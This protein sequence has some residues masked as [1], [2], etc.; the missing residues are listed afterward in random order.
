MVE[1]KR[2]RPLVRLIRFAIFASVSVVLFY[3]IGV[4]VFLSTSL[5]TR[6][7]DAQPDVVDIHFE[8]AWSIF[9]QHVHAKKL[10]IRG[11]DGNVE[12]I[13]KLDEAELDIALVSLLKMRFEGSH[14]RGKG[15][16]FRMRQRPDVAPSAEELASL[17]A[18]DGLAPYSI[19]PP[20]TPSPD[21]WNDA[22]YHLWTLDLEDVIAEDVREVWVDHVRYEGSAYVA[23]RF[24][25]KP[26]RK[27]EVGPLRVL[28]ERGALSSGKNRVAEA[29]DGSSADVTVEPFDP[30]TATLTDIVH[31]L[32]CVSDVHA[33][34]PEPG[35][36][37]PAGVNVH[38]PVELR[39][40]VLRITHGR[41]EN[42]SH[43]V[44]AAPKAVVSSGAYRA[45]GAITLDG[46]VESDRLDFRAEIATLDARRAT[47]PLLRASKAIATGDAAALDLTHAFEDLH[48]VVDVPDADLGSVRKLNR[49]IPPKTP[50]AIVKGDAR[51]DLHFEAWRAD[52]RATGRAT[53]RSDNLDFRLAKMNVR[54][55]A[56]VNAAFAS[57]R[58]G[59]RRLDGASLTIDV[60]NGELASADAPTTPLVRV[61]QARLTARASKMDSKDPLRDLDVSIS[62]PAADVVSSDL[63]HAYLPKGSEM[64]L[65]S[66]RSR[67][68]L[69]VDVG[70]ANHLARGSLDLQSH[71][72][73]LAYRDF[74]LD[75]KLAAH[76][77]VHDWRWETGDLALDDARVDVSDVTMAK[78]G[79][80]IPG[81]AIAKIGL[82]AK[83][84]R[85][86]FGDPL[87]QV[88]LSAFFA[89]ARV[90]DMSTLNAFLPA[91][92][93]FGFEGDKAA[94][95][96][97]VDIDVSQHSASGTLHAHASNL[98]AGGKTL[99]VLGDVDLAAKFTDWSFAKD[100]VDVRDARVEMSHVLGRFGAA[101]APDF[102]VERLFVSASTS[103]FD[104]A[105]PTLKGADF[106]LVVDKGVLP[107]ARAL[108][109]LISPN[110]VIKIES[111]AVRVSA[112]VDVSY[113]RRA[114]AGD[115]VIDLTRAGIRLHDTRLSGN[116]RFVAKI[117]G[118]DPERSTLDVSGTRLEMRDIAVTGAVARTSNWRGDVVLSRAL[119]RLEPDMMLDAVVRIDA[120]DARPILAIA[121]GHDLPK[122]VLSLT[123]VPHLRASSR[124]IVSAKEVALLD[125]DA[126]GGDL[127]LYGNYATRAKHR[128]AGIVVKKAFLSVGLRGDDK[129]VHLRFFGLNGWL[130]DRR[131]EVDAIVARD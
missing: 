10:S 45:S 111:G 91:H 96:A 77:R 87:A 39:R 41:L 36:M 103:R 63:L 107:D 99:H 11:R 44:V 30:R 115:V 105:R 89:D 5:F 15:L 13:V 76:A 43:V 104:I 20:K 62:I 16:S 84:T 56:S 121:F 101:H 100:T 129:G 124:V 68:A 95:D 55:R 57:Y 7:V 90:R 82:G 34:L 14:V 73:M 46:D 81:L 125:F 80:A 61:N 106:H 114:A 93:T 86:D 3:L 59:T 85:F 26:N 94:F 42:D 108:A 75:A 1:K 51:A 31:G 33:T 112:K 17:P 116:L 32:S 50:V 8:R 66:G 22:L 79:A 35:R 67:F 83:S 78:G 69:K 98:G 64:K 37:S 127:A 88:T 53:L 113:E 49:F 128:R 29:F 21:L 126:R 118:F 27:V 58:F 72:L 47:R 28:A 65:L 102:S 52:A 54:G 19:R 74:R 40:G 23:G 130:R 71:G 123:D 2:R 38:G 4:N 117:A 18:I 6:F 122:L 60:S 97:R 92:A 70:I 24:Y 109:P 120:R 48:I 119:L 110:G 131:R 25:F 9:P 12:W